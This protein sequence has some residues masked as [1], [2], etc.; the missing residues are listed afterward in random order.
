MSYKYLQSPMPADLTGVPV[1]ID[2]I[3]P[4]G[5][6]QHIGTVVSD[7]SGAYGCTWTPTV[8]GDYKVT[9]TFAGSN[10]YGMSWAQTYAT[11][12]TAPASPT[13]IPT[14]AQNTNPPYEM[15]TIGTGIAIIIAIAIAVLILKKR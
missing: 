5:N 15:Y 3:D 10:A 11:V 14:Q 2:A 6:A 13:P 9:A 1:S 8:A 7:G 4:N 12:S